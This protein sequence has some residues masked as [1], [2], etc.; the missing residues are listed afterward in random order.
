MPTMRKMISHGFW[1]LETSLHRLHKS[2]FL[3]RPQID[4]KF[5]WPFTYLK[6]HLSDFVKITF[7]MPRMQKMISYCL[8]THWNIASSKSLKSFFKTSWRHDFSGQ[9]AYLKH[10][11]SD[12]DLRA[13]SDAQDAEMLWHALSTPWIIASWASP[14]LFFNT[15]RR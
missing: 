5:S 6:H 10:H 14:K 4:Y 13:F 7:S 8:L 11:L 2:S 3:T 1:H 9:F 12:F 15:F